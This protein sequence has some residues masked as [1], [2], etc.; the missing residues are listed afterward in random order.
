MNDC[1]IGVD[2][3]GTNVRVGLVSDKLELIRKETA[4][5][6]SFG[7]AEELF[8][9]IR[10]MID[11]VDPKREAGKIGIAMPVPWK[12]D[13]TS[14]VD[15]VNIP[16]LEN[17]PTNA[18]T[19]FFPGYS[20]YFENDVNVIACLESEQGASKG[21]G[22]SVYITVSTGIGSGIIIHN[23][24]LHGAHGYAGEIGSMII[25]DK[26]NK[27]ASLYSGTLESLCSGKALEEESKK[28]YGAGATTLTLFERYHQQD[29]QAVLVIE[30][31]V[32]YFSRAIASLM[33]TMDPDVFVLGGSVID[34]NLWLIDKV[35]ENARTKVLENLKDGIRIVS[36]VFGGDAGVIGAGYSARKQA[37]KTTLRKTV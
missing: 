1:V 2:I 28:L 10:R 3:G 26:D 36:P 9:G 18:I 14:I 33:Q 19:T 16:Y 20:V 23:E 7:S 34:N 29:E 31:W 15:S 13:T 25:S 30:L 22:H 35:L 5:T 4:L 37:Q 24:V 27:H 12:H 21:S 6:G 17:V 8:T 32:E 11:S